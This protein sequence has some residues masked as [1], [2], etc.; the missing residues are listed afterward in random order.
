MATSKRPE[1]ALVEHLGA[2]RVASGGSE[3]QFCCPYVER[4]SH[5]DVGFHLYLNTRKQKFFCQICK[6]GGP[7]TMLYRRFGIDEP[8]NSIEAAEEYLEQWL[9]WYLNGMP[10]PVEPL[11][12]G[13]AGFPSDYIPV[14]KDTLAYHYL[15]KRGFTDDDIAFYRL[16]FGTNRLRGRIIIPTMK[17]GRCIYW[18]ARSYQPEDRKPKYLNPPNLSRSRF[19]F[20]FE[21]ASKQE[22][23]II[24]E[25]PLSAIAAGRNAIATFGVSYT[26]QQ[27]VMLQQVQAP[28]LV[29]YDGEALEAS[30][31][32]ARELA[33]RRCRVAIVPL[34]SGEDPASLGRENFLAYVERAMVYTDVLPLQLSLER[35]LAT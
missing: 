5:P 30:C 2:Y 33:S 25:G 15:V 21:Y 29:A 3:F 32:L 16:G 22:T 8:E 1:L 17:E 4:H 13:E 9:H 23:V 14:T 28:L 6:T 12:M 18:T 10:S 26:K 7:L 11:E 31:A 24:C 27:I 35:S 34:P 20:N 19:L